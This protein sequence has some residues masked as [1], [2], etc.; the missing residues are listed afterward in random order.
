MDYHLVLMMVMMME[1][2]LKM[3]MERYLEYHL[4]GLMV[5]RMDCYLV[6]MVTDDGVSSRVLHDI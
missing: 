1:N 5:Q 3:I 6:L 4:E 2:Y